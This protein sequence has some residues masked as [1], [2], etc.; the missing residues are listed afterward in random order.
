MSETII[1]NESEQVLATGKSPQRYVP[2][3]ALKDVIEQ[4]IEQAWLYGHGED[5]DHLLMQAGR[6]AGEIIA[7][8][9]AASIA[10]KLLAAVDHEAIKALAMEKL[11]SRMETE[12]LNRL[13]NSEW[14]KSKV[15]E[16]AAIEAAARVDSDAVL[17]QVVKESEIRL[18]EVG[19]FLT[20]HRE[21]LKISPTLRLGRLEQAVARVELLT[22]AEGTRLGLPVSTEVL[23]FL[24]EKGRLG[25]LKLLLEQGQLERQALPETTTVDDCA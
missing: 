17:Q 7:D 22:L 9:L 5:R 10:D 15:L 4:A 20:H 1:T 19:Q 21:A 6:C 13:A 25:S 24:N 2:P 23:E 11:A 16:G 8:K 18:A 12:L 3:P 14:M